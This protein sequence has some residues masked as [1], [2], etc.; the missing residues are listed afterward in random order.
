MQAILPVQAFIFNLDGVLVD[1]GAYHFI[2]WKRLANSLGFD[3]DFEQFQALRGLSRMTSLEKIL[4]WGNIYLTEAEKLHLTDVKNN[5]YLELI[6]GVTPEHVLP[7]VLPFLNALKTS[8]YPIALTSSSKSAKQVLSSTGLD[9][10]F[11]V[12]VD[13]HAFRKTIPDPECYLLT[14]KLLDLAPASCLVFEDAALG[15]Q[16]AIYGGFTVIGVGSL[17]NLQQ[18]HIVLPGL[19][20]ITL[21]QLAGFLLHHHSVV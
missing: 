6:K 3:F 21:D 10:F 11:D 19:E 15:V 20:S 16:A 14:A 4:E 2:A 13:G 1:T 9:S 7:G 18:A 17:Q 5:W 12:V 8:G